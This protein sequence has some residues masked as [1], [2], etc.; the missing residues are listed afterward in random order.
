MPDIF[1]TVYRA[2]IVSKA[3]RNNVPAVSIASDFV[4]DGGLLSYGADVVDL[5]RGV[6]S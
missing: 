2:S 4:R 1:I 6:A 3:A 5:W